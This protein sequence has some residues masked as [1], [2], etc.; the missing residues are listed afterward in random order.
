MLFT[1]YTLSSPGKGNMSDLKHIYSTG[2]ADPGVRCN[3]ALP[4]LS[5]VWN[6]LF[7]SFI[8]KINKNTSPKYLSESRTSAIKNLRATATARRLYEELKH[9]GKHYAHIH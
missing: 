6:A 4:Y 7:S 2:V 3:P 9:G 5:V 1:K 8:H